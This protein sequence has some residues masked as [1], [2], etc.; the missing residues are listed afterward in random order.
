MFSVM[1]W[2]DLGVCVGSFMAGLFS[3]R[4]SYRITVSMG[5]KTVWLVML[6]ALAAVGAHARGQEDMRLGSGVEGQFSWTRYGDSIT[7]TGYTG[8][9]RDIQIPQQIQGLPVTEIAEGAFRGRNLSSAT[10]PDTVVKI[11]RGAFF[12]NELTRVIIGDGVAYI[13]EGAFLGNMIESLVLPEGVAYIGDN[14]FAV[15]RLTALTLPAGVDFVGRWAFA[16][17]RLTDVTIGGRAFVGWN[18][19]DNSPNAVVDIGGIA[20]GGNAFA[21]NPLTTAYVPTEPE[22]RPELVPG[23]QL[24][25]VPEPVPIPELRLEPFPPPRLLP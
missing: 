17:N 4:K 5:R 16:D 3:A 9:G 15:N 2:L 8:R 6:M 10:I 25:P 23:P 1:P 21:N 18:S 14:A 13:G 24:A 7:V 20:V 12:Y 19:F 22:P 11:G